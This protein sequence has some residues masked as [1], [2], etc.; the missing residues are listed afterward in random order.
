MIFQDFMKSLSQLSDPRFRSVLW[1]GVGL[2]VL[3][4]F[5]I[6]ALFVMAI[7]V[8]VP[9]AIDLPL[10]GEVTFLKSLFSWG[11][12]L[13][14]IPLS[15]LL[16][17]PVASAFTGFFLDEV[18]TAVED[19]HYPYLAA[20]PSQPLGDTI[21]DTINFFGLMIGLNIIG[22]IV[23]PFFGP[24]AP[25]MFLGLNGFLL[26]REYFQMA[27]MRRIGRVEGRKLQRSNSGEIWLA[28]ALMA[29]PLFVPIV[30]LFVPVLAAAT[31]TH[32]FQRLRG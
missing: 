31:F 23:F 7:K 22:L 21:V 11:T 25:L 10:I 13:L 17:I 12:L 27:A 8:F 3:L 5:A 32:M 14:M 19:R 16:M 1:R 30:N 2:S 9:E 4:L 26:G 20:P 15:M 28:G 6:Y 24:L 18:A 29:L